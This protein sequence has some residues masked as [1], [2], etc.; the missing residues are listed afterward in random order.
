MVAFS[1]LC[2]HHV[3]DLSKS[4]ES[5]K[6]LVDMLSSDKSCYW[7]ESFLM[8]FGLCWLLLVAIISIRLLISLL[9]MFNK[10]GC[11]V[12]I[13]QMEET[14]VYGME[15]TSHCDQIPHGKLVFYFLFTCFLFWSI[16]VS[17]F[18]KNNSYEWIIFQFQLPILA[19]MCVYI[20]NI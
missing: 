15:V 3:V 5:I 20:S 14:F 11:G 2:N 16:Y 6:G 9:V 7:V 4:E 1:W 17:W 19:F 10:I 13:T 18:F 12:G 8:M